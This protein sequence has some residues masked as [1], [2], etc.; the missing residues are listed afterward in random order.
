MCSGSENRACGYYKKLR[1]TKKGDL[2]GSAK[3]KTV[4]EKQNTVFEYTRNN[5]GV[6]ELD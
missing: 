5:S 2:T 1:C 3:Y 4:N 6:K